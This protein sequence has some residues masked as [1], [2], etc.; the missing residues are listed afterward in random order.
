MA[1]HDLPSILQR[2]YRI[3]HSDCIG[4]GS[5][6]SIFRCSDI[7]TDEELAVKVEPNSRESLLHYEYHILKKLQNQSGFTSVKCCIRTTTHTMVVMTRLGHNL[8]ELWKN[9]DQTFSLATIAHIGIQSVTLLEKLHNVGF[10]HRDIKPENFL[11]PYDDSRQAL[12]LID[13]GL[14]KR[15]RDDKTKAH[16][17]FRTGKTMTGTP[18]YASLSAHL[19]LEQGRKDDLLSLFYV[20]AF[21]YFGHLPWMGIT[22]P[23]EE[24]KYGKIGKLKLGLGSEY[25]HRLPLPLSTLHAYLSSLPFEST[26]KYSF[27]RQLLLELASMDQAARRHFGPDI[28]SSENSF[29]FSYQYEW[30]IHNS[31]KTVLVEEDSPTSQSSLK[32]QLDLPPPRARLMSSFSRAGLSTL[33]LMTSSHRKQSQFPEHTQMRSPHSNLF[34]KHMNGD[35]TD[36]DLSN[37]EETKLEA[38]AAN[39]EHSPVVPLSSTPHLSNSTD[40]LNPRQL[41]HSPSPYVH[42][43]RHNS[44]HS[45]SLTFM[46][47][48]ASSPAFQF[49]ESQKAS[50][51]NLAVPRKRSP[52]APRNQMVRSRSSLGSPFLSPKI[53]H[54][55]SFHESP[56]SKLHT[57]TSKLENHHS[58]VSSPSRLTRGTSV[59]SNLLPSAL[60]SPYSSFA[61]AHWSS[62]F[63]A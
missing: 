7:E 50:Q 56:Q 61:S 36:D 28:F 3:H 37:G 9:N 10:I 26:P 18:R 2:R 49:P 27:I 16:I 48:S 17:P 32:F 42:R 11:F 57:P 41:L 25:F 39:P 31:T 21:F 1:F 53:L 19:G 24:E 12:H 6:G 43:T 35:S 58:S 20:L 55:K 33:A 8:D 23:T 46:A 51:S 22:A 52:A 59:S 15:Y 13:F 38:E 40:V 60:A 62:P 29:L 54:Q 14:S 4:R 63:N 47:K 34:E 45:P 30:N 5:F 44:L